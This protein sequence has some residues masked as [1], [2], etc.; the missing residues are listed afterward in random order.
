MLMWLVC[1]LGSISNHIPSNNKARTDS[2]DYKLVT[3]SPWI[4]I[5]YPFQWGLPIFTLSTF[6]TILPAQLTSIFDSLGDYFAAAS[7]TQSPN[8]PKQVMGRGIFVEGVS[9]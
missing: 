9:R 3:N 8:P 7:I 1:F 5:P 6:M 4:R 2:I